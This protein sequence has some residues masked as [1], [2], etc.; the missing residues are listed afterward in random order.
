[1][2]PEK[3]CARGRGRA[4]FTLVEMLLYMIIAVVVLGAVYKVMISQ[5]QTY[6]K[7]RELLDVRESM[8]SAGALLDWDLRQ[9]VT[10]GGQLVQS[11]ADSVRLRSMKGLGIICAKHATLPR[12]A[13]WR[14]SGDINAT[15]DDSA[16]IYH[17]SSGTWRSVRISQVGT[18]AALGVSSC[19]WAAGGKTP[20]LA[21]EVTVNATADT[22]G[23]LVGGSL[24]SFRVTT[25]AEY[26][27]SGRWWLGRKV[28]AAGAQWEK[29]TGPLL[30]PA[31]S[32]V[33]FTY[34]DNT[35]TA[36]TTPSAV[37]RAEFVLK[38]QSFKQYYKTSGMVLYQIDSIRT[39]V[40]LRQ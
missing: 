18:P 9:A 13:L 27:E 21:V 25:Y 34:W 19:S 28:G 32:G 23:V 37:A 22:A 14:T 5:S 31:A 38:A 7:E 30:S 16:A 29:L 1:M 2:R 6:G 26:Q 3:G 10:G 39:R 11:T 35:N 20:D 15:T 40:M 4:G 8:R 17:G 33:K 36:T 24:R 12:Y